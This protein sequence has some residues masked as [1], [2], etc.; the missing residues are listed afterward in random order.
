MQSLQPSQASALK[1]MV[2]YAAPMVP[3]SRSSTSGARRPAASAGSQL[4]L[5]QVDAAQYQFPHDARVESRIDAENPGE[6]PVLEHDLEIMVLFDV[7]H[8]FLT[9]TAD[10]SSASSC[11]PTETACWPKKL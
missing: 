11:T 3:I 2:S 4:F 1:W 5:A 8:L 10:A 7:V 6:A 9:S